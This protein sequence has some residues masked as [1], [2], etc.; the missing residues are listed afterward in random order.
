MVDRTFFGYKLVSITERPGPGMNDIEERVK[1]I[2]ANQLEI[3]VEK[4]SVDAS[5]FVDLGA[6]SIDTVE[7]VIA[8]EVEFGIEIPEE[9]AEGLSTI[10]D[11][12][13]Y[14]QAKTSGR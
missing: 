3:N 14:I 13:T 12:C 6:D 11:I 8:F 9:E 10:K 1:R 7:L 4:L 2:I 5:L